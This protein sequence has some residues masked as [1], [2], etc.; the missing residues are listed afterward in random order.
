MHL[1]TQTKTSNEKYRV[2]QHGYESS[3]V[4]YEGVD[5]G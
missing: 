1:E 3:T 4:K 2:I 5:A